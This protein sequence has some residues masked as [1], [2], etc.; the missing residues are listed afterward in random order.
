MLNLIRDGGA[1]MWGIILFGILALAAATRFAYR[2][3]RAQVPGIAS[4]GLSVL[5]SIFCGVMADIAAVG[6]QVPARPEWA[7]D[8]KIHLI[9]LRGLA[10]S[11]APGILGF[12]VLSV[13]ALLCAVGY[14]RLSP[15]AA[16]T[17]T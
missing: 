9:L 15:A 10:E 17:S 13:V 4:L 5:F 14:R 8:P 1:P 3:T 7:N 6:S 16:Q 2:P 12:S 11:M